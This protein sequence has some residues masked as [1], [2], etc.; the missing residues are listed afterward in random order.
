MA[1]GGGGEASPGSDPPKVVAVTSD[2]GVAE[3]RAAAE[4]VCR[5]AER[6]IEQLGPNPADQAE[7]V[8]R[9]QELLP[10]IGSA[11]NGIRVLAEPDEVRD[12]VQRLLDSM[13]KQVATG[14][15]LVNAFQSGDIQTAESAR[16]ELQGAGQDA[17]RLMAELGLQECVDFD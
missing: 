1:F 10:I 14:Q 9:L 5:V 12:D 11:A 8:Q 15:S 7:Q 3:W 6:R 2:A 17:D 4:E 16:L 13:D